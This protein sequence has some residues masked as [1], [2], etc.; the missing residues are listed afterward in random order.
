MSGNWE[1]RHKLSEQIKKYT[2]LFSVLYAKLFV[3]LH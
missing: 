3:R 2:L 1:Q